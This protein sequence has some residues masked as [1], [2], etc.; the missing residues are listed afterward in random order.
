MRQLPV[1]LTCPSGCV[2]LGAGADA[3]AGGALGHENSMS[4]GMAEQQLNSAMQQLGMS[5]GGLSACGQS[6]NATEPVCSRSCAALGSSKSG[7]WRAQRYHGADPAALSLAY[8]AVSYGFESGV[9]DSEAVLTQHAYHASLGALTVQVASRLLSCPVGRTSSISMNMTTPRASLTACQTTPHHQ[10]TTRPA[11]CQQG[12]WTQTA[13]QAAWVVQQQT[14]SLA[15][16]PR[17]WAWTP[18][19]FLRGLSG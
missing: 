9:C 17:Q 2:S 18:T 3:S 15:S 19:T 4:M 14:A 11:A 13:A 12:A 1:V 5:E 8:F 6:Y 16:L 7:C 10:Q